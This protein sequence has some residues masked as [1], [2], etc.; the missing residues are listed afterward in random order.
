MAKVYT[1][2]GLWL[3]EEE[4]N[5]VRIGLSLWGQDSAGEI[6]YYELQEEG[7]FKKG[8][9]LFS[10]EGSKAVTEL[11]APFDGEIVQVNEVLSAHP[12]DLNDK[13]EDKN[14][15]VLVTTD[16]FKAEDY[17]VEDQPID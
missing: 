3:Q 10:V 11:E 7:A 1:H 13:D 15:F 4:E 5:Q 12:E 6:S 16:Q 2:Y 8:D 9:A 17:L 14:W